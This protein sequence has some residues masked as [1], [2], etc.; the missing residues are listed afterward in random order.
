MF[1]CG[2]REGDQPG[3]GTKGKTASRTRETRVR[4]A[5]LPFVPCSTDGTA[6]ALTVD[7][8]DEAGR[9]RHVVHGGGSAAAHRG[10]APEPPRVGR[11]P[12]DKEKRP[13]AV[14]CPFKSG[15]GR[16]RGAAAHWLRR[17]G[18]R[19][20]LVAPRGLPSIRRAAGRAGPCRVAAMEPR[21]RT[22]PWQVRAGRAERG[23][24]SPCRRSG[25]EHTA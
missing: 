18:P 3:G 5:V 20:L 2:K 24:L 15:A 9:A 14:L 10:T 23:P 6:V 13:G 8:L 19:L 21:G 12:E 11:N 1:L 16:A 22:A 25:V 4:D 7:V 17:G